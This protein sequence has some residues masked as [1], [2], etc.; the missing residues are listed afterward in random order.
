MDFEKFKKSQIY[1]E[2]DFLYLNN[3]F[4]LILNDSLANFMII[5]TDR[6]IKATELKTF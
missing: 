6:H 4:Y 3:K 2:G 1:L 5:D